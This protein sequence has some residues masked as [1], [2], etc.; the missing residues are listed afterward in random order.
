VESGGHLQIS[1]EVESGGY[2]KI[3]R[4]KWSTVDRWMGI[5]GIAKMLLFLATFICINIDCSLLVF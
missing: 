5:R 3:F 1:R 4:E 2:L